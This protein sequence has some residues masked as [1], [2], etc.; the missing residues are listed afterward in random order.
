MIMTKIFDSDGSLK[1]FTKILKNLKIKLLL[2]LLKEP[3]SIYQKYAA[4]VRKFTIY[5]SFVTQFTK[6]NI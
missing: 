2:K 1:N 6:I 5:F 4:W 3:Y